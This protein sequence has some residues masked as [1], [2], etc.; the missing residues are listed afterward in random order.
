MYILPYFLEK[1]VK[2]LLKIRLNEIISNI[3]DDFIENLFIVSSDK[4]YQNTYFSLYYS[5][6]IHY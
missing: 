4:K 1:E 3:I 6:I 2:N 5:I